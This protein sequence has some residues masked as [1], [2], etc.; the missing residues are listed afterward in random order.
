[1]TEYKDQHVVY[2]KTIEELLMD[3]ALKN[4]PPPDTIVEIVVMAELIQDI[5]M[6]V[7]ELENPSA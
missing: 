4:N 1:M 5:C 6:R 3:I 7:R 2:P